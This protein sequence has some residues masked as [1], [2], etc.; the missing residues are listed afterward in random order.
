[1]PKIL[2]D[3]DLALKKIKDEVFALTDSSLYL[4][5][6]K[7]KYYPVIGEGNHRAK[8]MF[9]GEAPGKNEAETGRPFC[10]AA[11]RILDN[12]LALVEIK[13]A[14][15]YISNILKDRPPFNRD[16]LPEEIEVYA[17]FL[18]RQ[19][20]IIQPSVIVALGRYSTKYLMTRFRLDNTNQSISEL[21][22]REFV[23]TADYGQIKII[24]L[25]HPAAA[26]YNQSLLKVL[27]EDFQILKKYK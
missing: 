14:D 16:P 9:V 19:I 26:I 24:P 11:G 1:M 23:A 3:K 2:S 22:G 20:N 25:Y 8:I 7:N 4:Y 6:Q 27:E 21:H 15:V 10:G 18:D 13:R 12:L 17:P 5:R